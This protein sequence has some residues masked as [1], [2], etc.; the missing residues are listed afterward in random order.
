[1]VSPPIIKSASQR[2][3]N[4]TRAACSE[5]TIADHTAVWSHLITCPVKPMTIV[6]AR[7]TTPEIQFISRGNLY[8]AVRYT[9]I[10]WTPTRSIMADAPQLWIPRTIRPKVVWFVMYWRL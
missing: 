10:M 3:M 7:S 1:M 2:P 5:A 6:S 4:G 9:C 8:A